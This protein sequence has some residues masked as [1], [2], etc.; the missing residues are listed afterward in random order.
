MEEV[1]KYIADKVFPELSDRVLTNTD[2]ISGLPH[3]MVENDAN[4]RASKKLTVVEYSRPVNPKPILV[5]GIKLT[6]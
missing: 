4:Q 6:E 1:D 5:N 2:L 3:D